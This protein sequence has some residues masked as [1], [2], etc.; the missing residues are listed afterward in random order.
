[1]RVELDGHRLIQNLVEQLAASREGAWVFSVATEMVAVSLLDLVCWS[2]LCP[3]TAI[4]AG[5]H[6]TSC[7]VYTA[8]VRHP[9]VKSALDMA[10]AVVTFMF[11]RLCCIC[12]QH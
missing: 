8:Y 2:L 7:N 6:F 4:K 1:M 9:F 10:S 3:W 12:K 11:A 5:P